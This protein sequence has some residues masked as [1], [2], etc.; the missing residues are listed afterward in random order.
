MGALVGGSWRPGERY[1]YLRFFGETVFF[2][3]WVFVMGKFR[4]SRIRWND[5]QTRGAEVVIVQKSTPS[6]KSRGFGLGGAW[7]SR[8]GGART[9][10]GGKP[11]DTAAHCLEL[12]WAYPARVSDG[13]L[14]RSLS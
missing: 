2:F 11:P 4:L 14:R 1:L 10:L 12:Y 3:I 6:E 5:F 13:V 7:G 8:G 9:N